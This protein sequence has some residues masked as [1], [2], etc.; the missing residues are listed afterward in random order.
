MSTFFPQLSTVSANASSYHIDLYYTE[1]T[2][3]NAPI[4]TFVNEANDKISSPSDVGISGSDLVKTSFEKLK[5]VDVPIIVGQGGIA[6]C[7]YIENMPYAAE[8][9]LDKNFMHKAGQALESHSLKVAIPVRGAILICKATE[10]DVIDEINQEV[11]RLFQDFS[12]E[13]ITKLIFHMEEGIIESAEEI[14][15]DYRKTVIKP[16][17]AGTYTEQITKT[18]LFGSLYS[19]RVSAAAANIEDLQNGL[20]HCIQQVII[21]H[22]RSTDFSNS[23]EVFS[24]YDQPK[25]TKENL[26]AIVQFFS[27]LNENSMINNIPKSNPI[28]VSFL[29]GENF[30]NGEAHKKII[31]ILN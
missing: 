8:K 30:R 20:F 21:A 3:V 27:K 4:I 18:K 2:T 7:I 12:R 13:Q 24:D 31:T 26:D 19:I 10:K 5:A 28:K 11:H 25:L 14:P 9:I 17:N 6:H 15:I 1:D 29:F 22:G 16:I 23:I